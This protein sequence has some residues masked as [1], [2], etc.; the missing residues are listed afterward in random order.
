LEVACADANTVA[1]LLGMNG[2]SPEQRWDSRQPF[3][4]AQVSRFQ[5]T[6]GEMETQVIA[7]QGLRPSD[8][9]RRAVGAAVD[10]A[11]TC[12]VP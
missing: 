1:R 10:R 3:T 7:E 11:A 4:T 12:R 6:L 9:I 8:V 5:N 2:L